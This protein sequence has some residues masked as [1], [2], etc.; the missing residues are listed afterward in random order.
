MRCSTKI[1][2]NHTKAQGSSLR[3]KHM[4][5]IYSSIIPAIFIAMTSVVNGAQ[6]SDGQASKSTAGEMKKAPV[7]TCQKIVSIRNLSVSGEPSVEHGWQPE[8][9]SYNQISLQ[10]VRH[11]VSTDGKRMFCSYANKPDISAFKPLSLYRMA[12]RG[13][14]CKKMS[15][16]RFRC[17]K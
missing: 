5:S 15:D 14:R 17:S 2:R 16:F 6:S 8:F 1:P 7:F 4:K 12:P 3:E 9:S 13:M 10:V 11:Q